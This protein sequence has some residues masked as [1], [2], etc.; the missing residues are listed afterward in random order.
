MKCIYCG[1]EIPEGRLKALPNTK[2][3]VKCSISHKKKAITVTEGQGEDN[4]NDIVIVEDEDLNKIK[5]YNNKLNI[6]YD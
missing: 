4:W 6:S 1:V 3:C 5:Y 2:T